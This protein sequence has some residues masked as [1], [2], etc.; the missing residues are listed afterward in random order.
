[1]ETIKAYYTMYTLTQN[2]ETTTKFNNQDRTHTLWGKH[3]N[4]QQ[5]HHLPPSLSFLSLFLSLSLS[6][7]LSLCL[8]QT[9][10]LK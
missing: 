2:D 5:I 4:Q 1:M 7:S 9:R 3:S 8:S 10:R 6:L